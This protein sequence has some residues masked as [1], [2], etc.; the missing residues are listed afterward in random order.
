[1]FEFYWPYFALLLPLPLLLLWLRSPYTH[2]DSQLRILFPN[3]ARL[4]AAFKSSSGSA[5]K[6]PF[7]HIILLYIFWIGLVFALMRPQIV[8]RVSHIQQKGH[9]ILLAVDISNSMMALDFS[10]EKENKGRLDVTKNVLT[11]FISKRTTDRLGLILFGESAYLQAPLTHDT[12]QL[13][14]MLGNAVPGMAGPSTSIGDAIGVA[15]KNLKDKDDNNRILI[16]LTDGE[17]TAST[18]PPLEAAKIAAKYGIRI[19]TIGIGRRGQVPFPDEFGRIHMVEIGMDEELL[20][21]IAANTGGVYFKAETDS[22]LEK[23]Y[24]K[25][26]ELEKI[27]LDIRQYQIRTALFRYP[28]AIAMLAFLLL[29][30]HPFAEKLTKWRR[31]GY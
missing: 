9:D 21:A 17:D 26:D 3:M 23:V 14:K 16:L 1:M 15:V 30:I 6:S 28:L 20:Q 4:R 12:G 5:S 22:T 24:A 11:H 13:I 25:I 27:D 29:A 7:M 8:D 10:T 18:I 2:D 31:Y 19:Y